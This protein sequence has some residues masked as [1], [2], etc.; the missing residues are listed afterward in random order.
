MLVFEV[1][2]LSSYSFSERVIS[3]NEDLEKNHE[4]ARG[5]V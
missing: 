5:F 3:F 4:P 2:E 1:L